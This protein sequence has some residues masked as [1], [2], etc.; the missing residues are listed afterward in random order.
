MLHALLLVSTLSGAP[1][2]AAPPPAVVSLASPL[3]RVDD[4]FSARADVNAAVAI[5]ASSDATWQAIAS[6]Q[7]IVLTD[8]P[9]SPEVTVD[10]ALRRIEP[11]AEGGIVVAAALDAK[12]SLTQ[13]EVEA[14][15][16][17]CW[18]GSIVGVPGGRIFIAQCAAFVHGYA[19]ID[20][21]T[22]VISSGRPGD[23]APIVAYE[24]TTLPSD[25]IIWSPFECSTAIDGDF[26]QPQPQEGGVAGGSYPCRQVR[27]ALDSDNELAAVFGND[28]TATAAYLL[29][30]AASMTEIY[31]AS[32]NLRIQASFIRVWTT[33]DPWTSGSSGAQLTQ[34]RDYWQ[35]N[36]G[37]VVRDAA[38][39]LSA[40]GLGGG[41][42]W[43]SAMC[44]PWAYS[45]SG[46]LIGYFPYP[47]IDNAPQ[48][49]DVMVTTH[50]L[51]HNL[52]SPHTHNYCPP[53]DECAPNGYFGQC[54]SQ[55]V[56]TSAGTI[57]SYCHLC[58]GGM[59]NMVLD[60]APA[61]RTSID[62]H[63]GGTPCNFLGEPLAPWA[64]PDFV[65]SL[66]TPIVI[67]VLANDLPV[68]CESVVIDS[69]GQ[70]SSGPGIVTLSAGSGP[71]G[72]DQLVFTAPSWWAGISTFNYT[73]RD[74]S[75]QTSTPGTVTVNIPQYW[76]GKS[77]INTQTQI[78]VQ[79]FDLANPQALPY[80]DL[81][82]PYL[83]T[84][85]PHINYP[86]TGGVFANSNRSDN[87]G[88]VWNGWLWIPSDGLWTLSLDSDDGSKLTL[89]GVAV[90]NN[91]GLHGM[92]EKS[93]TLPLGRGRHQIKVEF[94][95]AGGGAGCI[96][97]L[98][99]PGIPKAPVPASS[100]SRAG[101]ILVADLNIDGQVNGADIAILL[102]VWDTPAEIG[103]LNNS[104]TVDGADLA[105]VLGNW[106]N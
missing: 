102:G 25:A 103:D 35:A 97:S 106:T 11:L 92:V 82:L 26:P 30:Q 86:S 46:N 1:A 20:D 15:D 61:C 43:L 54:Q 100:F 93:A 22:F 85:T 90:I 94:F 38:M 40:R 31:T 18:G 19:V 29:L 63:L 105:I 62:A 60:F 99:G 37:S 36:M 33:S 64:V 12:G 75:N 58:N 73:L 80:F 41:V 50:E 91:D 10:A 71:G 49:W 72:R 78:G 68:N 96:V 70:P 8:F 2:M 51:G 34:F 47:L 27:L 28:V 14:P 3:T 87:F 32:L 57:M 74:S 55:Q 67:D 84:T 6:Q 17:Q 52:G 13:T 39:L 45:V 66:T 77:V 79:Y 24:L 44:G 98:A 21:R 83:T 69:F 9:L 48:N 76:P 53:V 42:A 7:T 101:T 16:L 95:E 59:T 23:Q 104:G 88:A 56:C 5:V 89:D 65:A 4:P 81:M